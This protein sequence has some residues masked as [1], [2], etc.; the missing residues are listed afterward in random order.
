MFDNV[1]HCSG[2]CSV[3]QV[4]TFVLRLKHRLDLVSSYD[5]CDFEWL[6]PKHAGTSFIIIIL[7]E[8]TGVSRGSGVFQ[9]AFR[10]CFS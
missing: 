8:E 4:D 7:W 5:Q 9:E 3:M 10:L 2:K 1:L 6:L